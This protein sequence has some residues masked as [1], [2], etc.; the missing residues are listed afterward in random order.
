MKATPDRAA[1]ID[2]HIA[3]D[4]SE[5]PTARSYQA[6]DVLA[7]RLPKDKPGDQPA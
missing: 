5:L 3:G 7:L 2:K 6:G 1:F 4:T